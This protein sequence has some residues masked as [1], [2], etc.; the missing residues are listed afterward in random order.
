MTDVFAIGQ[1]SFRF[2]FPIDNSKRLLDT[3]ART[4]FLSQ[5]QL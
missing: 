4:F 3:L 5:F 1:D 2:A